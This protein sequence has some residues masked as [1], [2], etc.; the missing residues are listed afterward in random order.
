MYYKILLIINY[1][2]RLYILYFVCG[3]IINYKEIYFFKKM[4]YV[5]LSILVLYEC[6]RL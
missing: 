5:K 6:I 3:Y 2:I 4:Y 1:I